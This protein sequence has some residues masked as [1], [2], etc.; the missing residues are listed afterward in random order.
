MI[1]HGQT[2][3]GEEPEA[4]QEP[5]CI[6]RL[7]IG[8]VYQGYGLSVFSAVRFCRPSYERENTAASDLWKTGKAAMGKSQPG[9]ACSKIFHSAIDK[10][11]SGG[12]NIMVPFCSGEAYFAWLGAEKRRAC[13]NGVSR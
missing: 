6:R 13:R 4:A 7:M 1:G 12:Y 9:S 3:D 11:F 10:A 5:Y 8:S 2:E